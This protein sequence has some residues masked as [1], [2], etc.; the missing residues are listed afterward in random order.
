MMD[1]MELSRETTRLRNDD[2][3]LEKEQMDQ[4]SF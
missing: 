2:Q 1:F 3:Y 4:K